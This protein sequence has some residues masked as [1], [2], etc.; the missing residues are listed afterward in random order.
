VNAGGR[1]GSYGAEHL[2]TPITAV[3]PDHDRVAIVQPE[4]IAVLRL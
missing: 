1:A 4:G 2:P 3:H